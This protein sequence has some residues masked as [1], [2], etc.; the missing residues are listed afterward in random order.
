MQYILDLEE[1]KMIIVRQFLQNIPT[2]EIARRTS[3]SEE[4]CD[5][6]IKA[7][8]KVRKLYGDG[9][10]QDNIAAELDMSKTLVK[11]YIEIIEED[12]KAKMG[13]KD[14]KPAS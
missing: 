9:V 2:P 6:Y 11:Q 14:D 8:K 10:P 12:R 1:H 13:G 5:R 7:F 4:A 3:H